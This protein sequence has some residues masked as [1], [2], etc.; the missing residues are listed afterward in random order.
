MQ[1]DKPLYHAPLRLA[2][3][4]SYGLYG[5]SF[6]P[7]H[8]GHRAIVDYALQSLELHKVILLVTPHNPF[9]DISIYAP[10]SIRFADVK[11][12]I[13]NSHCIVSNFEQLIAS[14]NTYQTLVF[15]KKRYPTVQFTYIIGSDNL[16][17]LHRWHFFKRF[18]KLVRF[19]IIVRPTHRYC[20]NG[21]PAIRFFKQHH[22]SHILLLKPFHFISS[23]Q[24][25]IKN[26]SCDPI[27]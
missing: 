22:I 26:I 3:Q 15:L 17:H 27:Q 1:S 19:A 2:K 23:T 10:F 13:T 6:N 5:G 14:Q 11:Q 4:E 24:L 7:V 25:R 16:V 12:K 20:M 21:L 18:A 8:T 9:K